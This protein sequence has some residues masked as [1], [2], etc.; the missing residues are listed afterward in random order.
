MDKQ[1]NPAR[2]VFILRQHSGGW[3]VGGGGGAACGGGRGGGG[4]KEED[5]YF[6]GAVTVTL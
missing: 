5:E 3:R 1:T 4:W 6:I 2:A